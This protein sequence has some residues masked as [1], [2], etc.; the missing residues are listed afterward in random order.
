M[1]VF[2]VLIPAPSKGWGCG[3]ILRITNS[4]AMPKSGP[5][6]KDGKSSANGAV[7]ERR[8]YK[9]ISILP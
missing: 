8:L 1:L 7:D 5:Q 6:I 3:G 9:K 2:V 4:R